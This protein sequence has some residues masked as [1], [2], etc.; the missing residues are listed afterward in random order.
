MVAGLPENL[1]FYRHFDFVAFFNQLIAN[2]VSA[3]EIILSD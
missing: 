2:A 1:T 3:K